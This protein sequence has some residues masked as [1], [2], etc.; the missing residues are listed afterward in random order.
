MGR[1]RKDGTPFVNLIMCVPLR[2]Q[3][4]KVR[5]YLGAQL[6][7]TELVNDSTGLTTLKRLMR[8][9]DNNGSLIKHSDNPVETLQH[10]EFEQ[11][12]ET[13]NPQELES[14]VK[15]RQRQQL[16]SEQRDIEQTSGEQREAR[17]MAKT[18]SVA[19]DSTFELNGEG[20]APPL[21][22]YKTYLLVRPFPSLRIL[23][24][25]PDLRMPGILQSPLM[26]KIGGSARVRDELA[27]ALEVGRKVTAKIQWKSKTKPK[28][29]SRWIHCTPLL[30]VND[31]I[32]VWMVILVDDEDESESEPERASPKEQSSSSSSSTHHV[33][34]IPAQVVPWNTQSHKLQPGGVSTM[35]WSESGSGRQHEESP[36]PQLRKTLSRQTSSS[37]DSR[38]TPLASRPGPKIAGKSYSFTSAAH[39]RVSMDDD[40]C[41][42]REDDK[43]RP[44]T[45]SSQ[46]A[47]PL[48][49]SM[50]PKVKIPGQ[51]SV[52]DDSKRRPPVNM[53][54]RPGVVDDED[55]AHRPPA[56]RTYKSLS[57]YGILFQE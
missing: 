3:S 16:E 49:S 47:I 43:S 54:Y 27:H 45:S 17:V 32:G 11:L 18:P 55:G 40:G 15:L 5:Y 28:S 20:S 46:S 7:I 8:R 22:Y 26:S 51:F 10:D 4:G 14:L 48:K 52:D 21:G 30:G 53:P 33:P 56:R 1:S 9:H 41:S 37:G 44:T 13:F 24:A 42:S 29:R 50:Q 12:S 38:R 6:D 35:I 31:A 39:G 23:F 2:D 34:P 19:L 25:S 57:P 36:R